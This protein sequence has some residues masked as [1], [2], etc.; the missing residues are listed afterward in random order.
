MGALALCEKKD[1]ALEF[2][3]T[4]YDIK[5]IAQPV[6]VDEIRIFAESKADAMDEAHTVS[7]RKYPHIKRYIEIRGA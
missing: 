4:I 6:K 3:L 1:S 2:L 7:E 5:D